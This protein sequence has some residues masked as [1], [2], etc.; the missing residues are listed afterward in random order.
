M[1]EY[2]FNV[3]GRERKSFVGA[4]SEILNAPVNYLKAPS[5]AYEVGE[6]RIDKEGTVTGEYDHNLFERLAE[7]GYEPEAETSTEADTDRL[8]IEVPVLGFTP[9]HIENLNKMVLAKEP[10]LKKA[11][12]L[13]ELPIRMG[14]DTIQFPWFPAEPAE[15]ATCYVQFIHALCETAK[16]KKRITATARDFTNPRFSFRVWLIS[17][18][19]IGPEFKAARLAL[20]KNLS[21]NSAWS[22]GI[23]PRR[24]ATVTIDETSK[25]TPVE[26]IQAGTA[27][28]E[29]VAL[30]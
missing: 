5:F 17:L 11:L 19:M 13:D 26:D 1:N 25:G 18:G 15:N 6:Y 8:T 29:K 3:T 22:N 4:M 7:L 27:V 21:G 2:K 20:G 30:A 12:G 10:L 14:L 24:K 28:E 9:E 23:D 16:E